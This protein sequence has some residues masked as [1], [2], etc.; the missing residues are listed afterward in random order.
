MKVSLRSL[1]IVP[2]VL[3]IAAAVSLIGWLSLRNSQRAVNAVVY[4]LEH[5][6]SNRITSQL[7]HYLAVPHHI[8]RRNADLFEL[9]ILS[10]D[11]PQELER[12]L[13][14]QTQ[15]FEPVSDIYVS[16]KAGGFWSARRESAEG[17]ITDFVTATPGHGESEHFSL[18][19]QGPRS[20]SL[21]IPPNDA[22]QQ[23][24]WDIEAR[25]A[26]PPYWTDVYPLMPELTL[27]ISANTPLYD[28]SGDFQGILGVDLVL[29]DIADFLAQLDIGATGEAFIIEKDQSLIASSTQENPYIQATAH[30]NEERLSAIASANPMV[31]ATTQSLVEQFE[32]LES[33]HTAHH[34]ELLIDQARH[35]AQ[36]TPITDDFGIDW[37][38]IVVVP[39]ADFM[40]QI[41]ANTDNTIWL[42]L[43]ALTIAT[44]LGILTARYLSRPIKQLSQQSQ[45]VTTTLQDPGH[46]DADPQA[47][48][49]AQDS[50][51]AEVATLSDSFQQMAIAL[52]QALSELQTTNE[53]LEARVQ[54]RTTD[55][56]HAKDHAEAANQAK[57]NLLANMSHEL[58]TPLSAILGFTQLMQRPDMAAHTEREY[59]EII[60]HSAEHLLDLIDDILD[61][62]KLEAGHLALSTSE[63]DFHALLTLIRDM[64]APRSQ[65]QQLFL[66]MD[67]AEDIPQFVRGDEKKIRQILINLLGNALKFTEVG[68]ITV[69]VFSLPQPQYATGRSPHP[70]AHQPPL[71]V[72]ITVQDTGIG[73]A[74]EQL[75]VIFSSFSQ[76]H[77]H[78]EGTGLGLAISRQFAEVMGG[79]LTAHSQLGNGSTFT[80]EIPVASVSELAQRTD[81][82][83][84][85]VIALKSG[86]PTYRILIADD[87]RSNRQ[88]LVQ[89]LA[90]LGFELR[91]ASNG[92]EAYEIWTIWQ[93]HLIW[94][95]LQMPMMNGIE[96]AHKI[97]ADSPARSTILV[98]LTASAWAHQHHEI[99]A[100]GFDDLIHKPTRAH[101][102]FD[103]LAKHLGTLFTYQDSQ[104]WGGQCP[105]SPPLSPKALQVMPR[106]WCIDLKQA[107]TIAKPSTLFELIRQIP[108][109]ESDLATELQRM[110]DH[111]QLEA[112]IHLVDIVSSYHEP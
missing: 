91:E 45:A 73:I 86:Q 46:S 48:A 77:S 98:A 92:Q 106:Q 55:L 103:T 78:Y 102:I 96:L 110:V 43:G 104:S 105:R 94:V 44:G 35:F 17:A 36:V 89:L 62:A 52:N 15:A 30:Q 79:T 7:H 25:E 39:E 10:M 50:P 65:Q 76:L 60:H 51:I 53:A 100:Q 81:I 87:H 71:W 95:D 37:L 21:S 34:F 3:E 4:E 85:Q 72:Q 59:L 8:N 33:L 2:F 42:C 90:P 109:A 66:Q 97:Q 101:T 40:A 61:L 1:L 111:Y 27:A 16:S 70:Q 5:E 69:T 9:G 88:F 63:F 38:L 47:F 41:Q 12:Y 24:D 83:T 112:I 26:R 93:P 22:P 49:A 18:T 80:L 82:P 20:P 74:P 67:W 108:P 13:W 32:S 56:A 58:R 11:R 64:F 28:E 57:S 6:I 68:G 14:Q 84:R 23:R 99:L 54:Q 107:A 31:V 29:A 19:P 75:E